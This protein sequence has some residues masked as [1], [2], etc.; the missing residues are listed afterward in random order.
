MPMQAGMS[1]G[2]TGHI[3]WISEKA[4]FTPKTIQTRDRRANLVYAIKVSVANDGLIKLGMY[5]EVR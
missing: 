4:E 5:A 2:C 1:T 3:S